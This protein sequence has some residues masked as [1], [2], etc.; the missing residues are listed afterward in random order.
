MSMRWYDVVTLKI[1][2]CHDPL[3]H[4]R[5]VSK[6]P[7]MV[8]DLHPRH[9]QSTHH[10]PPR[11]RRGWDWIRGINAGLAR[12]KHKMFRSV[13]SFVFFLLPRWIGQKV[14]NFRADFM[15]RR[16]GGV[17]LFRFGDVK[18]EEAKKWDY[19]LLGFGFHASKPAKSTT[20]QHSPT[21]FHYL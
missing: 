12:L 3:H 20:T 10:P 18:W 7:C 14:Y 6:A 19:F 2:L 17:L 9:T 13:H 4:L 21:I 8:V 16:F 15:C 11:C 5:Y 1:Y